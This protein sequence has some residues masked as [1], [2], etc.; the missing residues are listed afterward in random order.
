MLRQQVIGA[1][2]WY[3]CAAT[4]TVTVLGS[5]QTVC[6]SAC[7][8]HRS[9][10]DL[11]EDFPDQLFISLV[12]TE[13]QHQNLRQPS[14]I[15]RFCKS[16]VWVTQTLL[17]LYVSLYNTSIVRVLGFFYHLKLHH[18]SHYLLDEILSKA[19]IAAAVCITA[20]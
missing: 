10:L 19:S 8:V 13:R 3:T 6:F 18:N 15:R 7:R 1:S 12:I 11:R 9:V 17:L 5:I 16:T 4:T 2:N 20:A 14:T